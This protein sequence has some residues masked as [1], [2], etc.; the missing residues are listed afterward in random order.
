VG[1]ELLPFHA[2]LLQAA[3]STATPVQP[4]LLRYA[5]RHGPFSAAARFVGDINLKRSLW[6]LACSDDMVV[7][8]QVLPPQGT[9]HADRRRLAERLR[10]ELQSRLPA[11]P[12]QPAAP[13]PA[14]A[15]R[16]DRVDA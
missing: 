3:I 7:H 6:L 14:T 4:V 10:D 8:V 9:A 1:P 16:T 2:N 5:D 11:G 15:G 12:A 13:A